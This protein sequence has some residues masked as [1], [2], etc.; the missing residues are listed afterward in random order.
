M[1]ITYDHILYARQFISV[2][3]CFLHSFNR[4]KAFGKSESRHSYLVW[5]FEIHRSTAELILLDVSS[6]RTG[7]SMNTKVRLSPLSLFMDCCDR[8]CGIYRT[9]GMTQT[10]SDK[11]V[12]FFVMWPFHLSCGHLTASY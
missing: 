4:H 12:N 3:E 1:I 11:P 5:S 7:Q 2:F 6:S 10:E 8:S 9:S